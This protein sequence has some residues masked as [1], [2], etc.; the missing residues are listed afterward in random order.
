MLG[1]LDPMAHSIINPPRG[2]GATFSPEGRFESEA[3]ESFDDGWG[4]LPEAPRQADMLAHQA[5]DRQSLQ[6]A[7]RRD[8]GGGDECLVDG[9]VGE[10]ARR[11]DGRPKTRAAQQ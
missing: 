2:R 8:D 11:P 1:Y 7:A 9:E 5:G 4:E 3:R 10:P 6:R